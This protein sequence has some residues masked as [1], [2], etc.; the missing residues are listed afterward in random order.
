MSWKL[1][2]T[3]EVAKSSWVPV[4]LSH[5]GFTVDW[6][7]LSHGGVT[8]DGDGDGRIHD[9]TS[10]S[11]W[12]PVDL[13]HGGVVIDH[14]SDGRVH[15]GTP[16]EHD[17]EERDQPEE[18]R[19]Q[20]VRIPDSLAKHTVNGELTEERR[21]LHEQI[22]AKV[23]GDATPVDDPEF[24]LMGGGP[25][26]GKSTLIRMGLVSLDENSVTIDSDYIKG[27]LPEYQQMLED[28]DSRAAAYAHEESSM[29][30]KEIMA[31]AVAGDYNVTLDGTGNSTMER[32]RRKTEAAKSRGHRLRAV[33]ATVPMDEALRRNA[34]RAKR[35]GRM[36]PPTVLRNAHRNVSA[37]LEQAVNDKLFDSFELWNT[38]GEP[39][40]VA[41][42]SG[43]RLTIMDEEKFRQFR[44]K[45][46]R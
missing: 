2:G 20:E 36:V 45:A 28:G 29:I 26:S 18:S 27:E 1:K 25:A 46:S 24:V 17:A 21:E 19:Q 3:S 34:E 39:N 13:S 38:E 30:S 35:T 11:R 23:F 15:D 43:Q 5:G 6:I 32:L 8:S 10:G 16:D 4:E 33:Y 42:F 31:R 22:I 9:G 37:V 12:I 40:Q 7:E 44:S 14:D 41:G